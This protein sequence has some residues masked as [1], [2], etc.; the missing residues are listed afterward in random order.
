MLT[1][2]SHSVVF[3]VMTQCSLV[4][5][6]RVLKEHTASNFRVQINHVGKVASYAEEGK[7]VTQECSIR[8]MNAKKGGRVASREQ[9]QQYALNRENTLGQRNS[10]YSHYSTKSAACPASPTST[11]KMKATCS[12][13]NGTL[14]MLQPL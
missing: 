11:L 2:T 5:D 4:C 13:K 10:D 6:I 12:L 1:Y 7:Q 8:T 9:W 3:Y 14:M